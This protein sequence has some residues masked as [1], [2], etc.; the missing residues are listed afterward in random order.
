MAQHMLPRYIDFVDALP[1]TATEKVE[2]Q[3]L[4]ARGV[5]SR[6]WDRERG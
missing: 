5:G 1:R 3:T 4:I 2:K 6:T